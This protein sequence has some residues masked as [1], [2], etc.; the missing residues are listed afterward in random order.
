MNVLVQRVKSASVDVEGSRIAHIGHGMLVLVGL[1][2]GD[3]L[4]SVKKQADKLVKFRIFADAEGKMNQTL[5]QVGGEFLV[6]SQFTLAAETRKGNRPGFD[7]AMAPAEAEALFQEYVAYLG[8]Q[9][10]KPVQTGQFGAHMDVALVN[11][12]PVTFLLQVPP[13]PV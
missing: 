12:G 1:E 13:S 6:V 5:D 9:T 4:E 7:N 2:K 3:T 10:Q 8:T 11:D